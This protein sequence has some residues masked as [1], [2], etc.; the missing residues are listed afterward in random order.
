MPL[1]LRV[2]GMVEGCYTVIRQRLSIVKVIFASGVDRRNMS[3]CYGLSTIGQ[4]NI[5]A[6]GSGVI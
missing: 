5:E 6:A 2:F 1:E 4:G 3:Q